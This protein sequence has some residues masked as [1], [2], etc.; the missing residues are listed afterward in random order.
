VHS[1]QRER[2]THP[3]KSFYNSARWKYTRRRQLHHHPLCAVCGEIATD[4]DHIRPV[5]DG[6]DPWSFTNLMSLCHSCHSMK[7]R[8]EQATR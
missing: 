5:E 4:V 6:G 3:R 1:R 7:T 2:T 8:R